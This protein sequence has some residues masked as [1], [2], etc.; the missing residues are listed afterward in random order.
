MNKE[1]VSGKQKT[2][3]QANPVKYLIFKFILMLQYMEFAVYSLQYLMVCTWSF[4]CI[5]LI[6]AEVLRCIEDTRYIDMF[7]YI[8]AVGT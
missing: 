7:R 8:D 6:Y 1:G 3:L 2:V 5:K 4:R